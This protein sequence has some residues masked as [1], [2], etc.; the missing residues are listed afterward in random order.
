MPKT[1]KKEVEAVLEKRVSKRTRGHIYFQYLVKWKGH[2]VEDASWF[3]T[4]ELQKYEVNPES[5]RDD[6][7]L[8]WE[9]DVGASRLSQ[10]CDGFFT[11]CG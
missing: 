4:I 6:S 3:T 1:V 5:L 9:S 8:P 2:P 7:F 11:C 10:Q